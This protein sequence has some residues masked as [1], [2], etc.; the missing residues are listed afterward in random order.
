MDA[1]FFIFEGQHRAKGMGVKKTWRGTSWPT[2]ARVGD[3]WNGA[4]KATWSSLPTT[5]TGPCSLSETSSGD[6]FSFVL[7]Y[8]S[9]ADPLR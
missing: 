7:Y 6:S 5:L 3:A 2:L 1:V 4:G 9:V 8:S